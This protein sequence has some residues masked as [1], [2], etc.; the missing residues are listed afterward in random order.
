M[1]FKLMLLVIAS[2]AQCITCCREPVWHTLRHV[3][4]P[5]LCHS[6]QTHRFR[7]CSSAAVGAL[8]YRREKFQKLQQRGTLLYLLYSL[9]VK[10]YKIGCLWMLT[11]LWCVHLVPV[12]IFTMFTVPYYSPE[13]IQ[14]K[15][16]NDK[17]DVWAIGCILY[18]MC[19]LKAPFY[20]NNMLTLAKMVSNPWSFNS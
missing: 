11:T 13:I 9:Y 18:Q 2:V 12:S 10:T 7:R 15:P 17:A 14:N 19:T 5:C 4:A 1:G 6:G 20:S 8:E 16:Y 3:F